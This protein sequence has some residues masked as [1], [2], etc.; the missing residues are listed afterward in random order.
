MPTAA[1]RPG[2]GWVLGYRPAL[3][4]LRGIA[5][6]L[7]MAYHFGV[8]GFEGGGH[9]GVTVFFVLSG[10]LITALL[11]E[12]RR[13]T[14]RI[15][16]GA[17]YIRRARRLLPALVALVAV[18]LVLALARGRL[19]EVAPQA[20]AVLFYVG[21]WAQHSNAISLAHL[22][23]AW[24][25]GVEEQFYL[26]WPVVLLVAST[27]RALRGAVIVAAAG[28]VAA[29]ALR[30][31]GANL[32][33]LERSV[34]ALMLGCLLAVVILHRRVTLPGYAGYAAMGLL[35][36]A[37]L[38]PLEGAVGTWGLL[39]IGLA[40]VVVIAATVGE[41]PPRLTALLEWRPLVFTGRISYGLY[42]WHFAVGWELWP[43]LSAA[44]WHWLPSALVLTAISFAMALISWRYVERP[45][46][47]W[48]RPAE[49]S[50]SAR[51]ASLART[52]AVEASPSS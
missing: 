7:V 1:A 25:L 24:S 17:F 2:E 35:A 11:L 29:L 34:D 4:G 3:D 45:V 51:S 44:G 31:V 48:R 22:S 8:P 23:H 28:V 39:V 16:I 6:L 14:A 46:L 27:R 10:F 36:V 50:R 43:A 37:A 30:L 9:T 47:A 18:V 32:A 13:A 5:V 41:R 38:L 20:F 15:D 26:V 49:G 40:S 33:T 19:G 21:N 12:E 42:L 52:A